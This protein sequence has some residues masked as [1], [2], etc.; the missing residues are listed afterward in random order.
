MK[1][2]EMNNSA[3]S[4]VDFYLADK[5]AELLYVKLGRST[6]LSMCNKVKNKMVESASFCHAIKKVSEWVNYLQSEEQAKMQLMR[7]G[8]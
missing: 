1:Q 8:L 2:S 5:I 6:Q 4:E 3:L 7:G